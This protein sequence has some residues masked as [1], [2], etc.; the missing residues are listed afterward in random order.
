MKW[1]KVETVHRPAKET[2]KKGSGRQKDSFSS[3]NEDCRKAGVKPERR[4]YKL[5]GGDW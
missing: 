5:V 1:S 2:R 3:Y 4:L